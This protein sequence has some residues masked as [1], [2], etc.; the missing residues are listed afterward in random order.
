MITLFTGH[1]NLSW[2]NF[3]ELWRLIFRNKQSWRINVNW[4]RLDVWFTFEVARLLSSL[5]LGNY[6]LWA[7]NKR[8]HW[9]NCGSGQSLQVAP[10]ATASAACI[11]EQQRHY[12]MF[13][14]A[15]ML[16]ACQMNKLIF[17][18][19]RVDN[20]LMSWRKE[21]NLCVMFVLLCNAHTASPLLQHLSPLPITG[22]P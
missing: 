15:E 10:H 11:G 16:Q 22:T 9:G 6:W 21:A 19:W 7:G 20:Y 12:L 14:R 8:R 5:S 2:R 17:E 18:L 13:Q 3:Y 4:L 1:E